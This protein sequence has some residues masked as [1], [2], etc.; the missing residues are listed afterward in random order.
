MKRFILLCLIFPCLFVSAGEVSEDYLDIASSYCTYGQYK[1]AMEYLDKI[2]KIEPDNSDVKELKST[3]LRVTNPNSKS[4]LT[5]VNKNIREASIYEKQGNEQN[6]RSALATDSNDFWS[7]FLLAELYKDNEDYTNSIIHFKK[8][9]D[10]K[11]AYSQSYLAIAQVYYN[12]GDYDNA[13]VNLNKYLSYNK[14]SSFAYALK[15]QANLKLNK[16]LDAENDIKKAIEVEEN[17]SYLLIEAKILY[18]KGDYSTAK[19]KLQ[20]ISQNIQT[21][22]VYKYAG[23]CDYALN[24]YADALLNIDKALILSDED[25]SLDLKYNEI[26]AI[27]DKEQ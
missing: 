12:N 11:P 14:N 17:V 15:A 16:I 8:C 5:T 7:N 20:T 19:D 3:I 9:I 21:S 24:N 10:M 22:E 4:Y 18:M 27:L 26:K 13:I 25:K 23:L 6:E 1:E 2:L